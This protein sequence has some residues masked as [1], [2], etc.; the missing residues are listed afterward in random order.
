MTM[1]SLQQSKIK[2]SRSPML[3][4][5]VSLAESSSPQLLKKGSSSPQTAKKV[6]SSPK[7]AK[8]TNEDGENN[9]ATKHKTEAPKSGRMT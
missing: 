7:V 8:K 9:H 4:R 2:T 6:N 1:D 3:A 5:R